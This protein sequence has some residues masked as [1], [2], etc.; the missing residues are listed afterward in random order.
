MHLL[1]IG[2]QLA[3]AIPEVIE[4]LRRTLVA[5]ANP[6]GTDPELWAESRAHATL[7]LEACA[8]A[9]ELPLERVTDQS[10]EE[11]LRASPVAGGLWVCCRGR[12]V[13]ALSAMEA[14]ERHTFGKVVEF[15]A[16]VPVG[17]RADVIVAAAKVVDRI[18]ALHA[19]T[20]AQSYDAYLLQQ[21]EQANSEDRGKLARDIHDHLGNWLVLA[22]RNLELYRTKTTE[23]S[24]A[25]RSHLDAI[26]ASLEQ[27]SGY[28]RGLVSGLRAE[29]PLTSLVEAVV[30]CADALNFGDTTVRVSVHGDETWLPDRHR[31]EVFL[32]VREFLRNS[33]AHAAPGTVGVRILIRPGSAEVEAFDDGSG[34]A[35]GEHHQSPGTGGAGLSVMRERTEQLGGQF[36]LCTEPGKGTRI[37]LWVPLPQREQAT[38]M[39]LTVALPIQDYMV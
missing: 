7:L 25:V 37:Q 34:F 21:I 6:L 31:G 23:E 28:T 11:E 33:F 26:H 4:R 9:L 14:L 24:P 1:H 2:K 3:L 18:G 20:A 10:L 16:A 39:G 32:I 17:A 35:F 29:A 5:A 38:T 27:A 19:K 12:I 8:R 36:S 13:D 15:S 30:D 22:F